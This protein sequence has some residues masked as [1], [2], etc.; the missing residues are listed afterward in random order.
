M[1]PITITWIDPKQFNPDTPQDERVPT[2][3]VTTGELVSE[4][5]K[6]LVIK[7]PKTIKK[8][9]KEKHPEKDPKFYYIP[10]SLILDQG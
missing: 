5:E 8:A 2:C 3:M 7:N 10:K 1:N 4:R 9:T 6:G